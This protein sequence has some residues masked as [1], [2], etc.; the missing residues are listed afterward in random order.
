MMEKIKS[1]VDCVLNE[2]SSTF[3]MKVHVISRREN[4]MMKERT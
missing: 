3:L 2:K 4:V 1:Y